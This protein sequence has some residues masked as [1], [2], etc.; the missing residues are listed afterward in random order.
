[1][2]ITAISSIL[3]TSPVKPVHRVVRKKGSPEAEPV[4]ISANSSSVTT[5]VSEFG[6]E[7]AKDETVEEKN[8][9]RRNLLWNTML[10]LW[11]FPKRLPIPFYWEMTRQKPFSTLAF[12]KTLQ[13]FNEMI[14]QASTITWS[15]DIIWEN[16]LILEPHPVFWQNEPNRQQHIEINRNLVTLAFV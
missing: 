5:S 12:A 2:R 1:M 4:E 9:K 14:G 11:P 8:Y 16:F 15:I 13:F 7:R 6:S 3:H 10:N